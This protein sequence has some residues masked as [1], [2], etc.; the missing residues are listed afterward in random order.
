MRLLKYLTAPALALSFIAMSPIESGSARAAPAA[1]ML[2]VQRGDAKPAV[3]NV[4]YRRWHHH[5]WHHRHHHHY[6][7]YGHRHYRPYGYYHR[8][9]YGRPYSY[10]GGYAPGLYLSIG[11]KFGYGWGHRHHRHW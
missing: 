1:G 6:R 4:H 9:Y 5:R 8:G 7:H 2:A 11:P 3:E 10:Y